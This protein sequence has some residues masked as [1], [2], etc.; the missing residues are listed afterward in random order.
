MELARLFGSEPERPA[1]SIVFIGFSGEELGLLGST[2]YVEHPIVPLD[3]TGAMVNMD[4]VGR[5]RPDENGVPVC[6][7]YGLGTASDWT[8]LIPDKTPDG[9]VSLVKF[10]SPLAGG[11]YVPFQLRQVPSI[12]FT[13]GSHDQMHRPTDDV[14]LINK[15]G[16][17][18][19]VR[20]ISEILRAVADFPIMFTFQESGAGPSPVTNET[21]TDSYTVYLGVI[22]DFTRVEG[23]FWIQGTN[24]GSP[25]EAAGLQGG[26]QIT[27]LGEYEVSDI[28]NFTW[29]LGQF[30]PGDTTTINV[31]RDGQELVLNVTFAARQ[32]E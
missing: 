3:K 24:P 17:A 1:R 25:A 28:Y 30:K 4:M 6:Y 10:S 21:G 14:E 7:V 29:A 8:N 31:V 16:E 15:D 11:D 32:Q 20:A 26:D 9:A 22:P 27:G 19:L 13:S 12:N 5:I 2:Y 18:S 23:G